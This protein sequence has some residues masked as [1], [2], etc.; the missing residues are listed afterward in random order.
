MPVMPPLPE[1][2]AQL[3]FDLV[4]GSLGP[5]RCEELLRLLPGRRMVFRGWW[6]EKPVL[7][8][9]FTGSAAVRDAQ[10]DLG[11]IAAMFRRGIPVPEPLLPEPVAAGAAR[12]VL[13]EYLAGSL[14]F[15]EAW[16][17]AGEVRRKALLAELFNLVAG[18]HEAGMVQEDPH[19]DN[20]LVDAAGAIRAIDGGA[21]R[22][23][24]GPLAGK[25]AQR[26]LGLLLAQFPRSAHAG[27]MA[28]LEV[29]CRRRGFPDPAAFAR[30]VCRHADR[31]RHYR[32]R[33]LSE[34]CLRDCTE[35]L[36]REKG[37]LRIF[38]RRELDVR[39]LD[40]WISG[41]LSGPARESDLLKAGNSQTVW[42]DRIGDRQVVVKRYNVKTRF[43][44]LRRMLSS[45]RGR[46]SWRN[47]HRVRGYGI[48]T[49]RPLA[50]IEERHGL[51]RRAWLVTEKAGGERADR[52]FS[53]RHGDREKVRKVASVVA[54]FAQ[55]GLV[56]GDMKASNFLVGKEDVQVIDLDSLSRPRW[57]WLRERGVRADRER[58]LRNWKD[59]ELRAA[60]EAAL[61]EAEGKRHLC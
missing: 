32:A 1:D 17:C 60:F 61:A 52:C 4:L 56:H 27:V 39:L 54:A 25:P 44:G 58:F 50:Y 7:A 26:N 14:P 22:L 11:A 43:H 18:Q 36:V 28:A 38:Q 12:V 20:F 24:S 21:Y 29:Y 2:P 46:R 23:G 51:R 53:G 49:P 19:L 9:V 47:A 13:Y 33:K 10:R 57:R 42:V 16:R 15:G 31:W 34:K 37:E 40:E 59:P 35:F 5:L 3:P 8:K 48:P 30:G 55:N 45:S 6:R 41:A